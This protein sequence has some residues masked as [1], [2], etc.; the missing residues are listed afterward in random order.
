MGIIEWLFFTRDQRDLDRRVQRLKRSESVGELVSELKGLTHHRSAAKIVNQCYLLHSAAEKYPSREL[1]ELLLSCGAD[2]ELAIDS[3][4]DTPL[5]YASYRHN[6]TV[7][8]CIID[9]SCKPSQT[10]SNQGFLQ[11]LVAGVAR[12]SEKSSDDDLQYEFKHRLIEARNKEGMT[13]LHMAAYSGSLEICQLLIEN[14]ANVNATDER[15]VTALHLAAE[16]GYFEICQ[17]LLDKGA[18]LDLKDDTGLAA[19]HCAAWSNHPKI[20]TLLIERGAD[21]ESKG[22]NSRTPLHLAAQENHVTCCEVLLDNGAD[23]QATNE[24]YRTPL[25]LAAMYRPDMAAI[26]ARQTYNPRKPIL[27]EALAQTMKLPDWEVRTDTD[28]EV[29]ILPLTPVVSDPVHSAH[30][31]PDAACNLLLD[32]GA[33]PECLDSYMKTP[34]QLAVTHQTITTMT[35]LDARQRGALAMQKMKNAAAVDD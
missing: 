22:P 19:L 17:H 28:D 27:C 31:D 23:I 21:L 2:V 5:H 33:D 24:K 16:R 8:Q 20:C 32:R 10:A 14:G 12:T 9:I 25:H 6:I 34:Q 4:K 30:L 13:P 29:T 15:Q 35:R 11:C 7:C 3:T 1:F 26:H 18:S